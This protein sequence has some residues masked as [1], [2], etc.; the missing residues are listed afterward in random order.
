MKTSCLK[1]TA[2]T[3]ENSKFNGKGWKITYMISIS[4]F[5]KPDPTFR[6]YVVI[7]VMAMFQGW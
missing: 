7:M 1:L 5:G 3:L 2:K 6:G 4:L